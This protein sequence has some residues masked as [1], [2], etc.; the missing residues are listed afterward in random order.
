MCDYSL[1]NVATRPAEV[2]DKLVTGKIA[3]SLTGGFSPIGDPNVAVCLRPGTEI[4][5]DNDI[6]FEGGPGFLRTWRSET[7]PGVKV[8]RFRQIDTDKPCVHHDALELPDGEI[9]LLTRLAEGQQATVL[10]LPASGQGAGVATEER[11]R[12]PVSAI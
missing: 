5:F 4:A 1:H 11:H 10:Q 9:V 12:D 7:R 2:G 3:N 6:T 8:A